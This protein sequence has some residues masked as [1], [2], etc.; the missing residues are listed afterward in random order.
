MSDSKNLSLDEYIES[1]E[2]DDFVKQ[3]K[4]KISEILKGLNT[5]KNKL[6]NKKD[7][8]SIPI[9]RTDD[10][11]KLFAELE[12][13][14][15]VFEVSLN[16]LRN[17]SDS[18]KSQSLRL[19][20]ENLKILKGLD[21]WRDYMNFL[22]DII[23]NVNMVQAFISRDIQKEEFLAYKE[24]TDRTVAA[25]KEREL[26]LIKSI[27]EVKVVFEQT[28]NLKIHDYYELAAKENQSKS[29]I[30]RTFFIFLII[31]SLTIIWFSM[32]TKGYFGLSGYDYYFFKGSLV[33]TSVT[34]ITYFLKQ[35]V[36][37]QK[38]ADQCKQT[39]LE[40]E[41]FPSYVAN[42]SNEDPLVADFRKELAMKYFGRDVDNKSN[43]ET[44]NILQDQMKNTTEMVKATVEVLKKSGSN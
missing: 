22:R 27:E 25:L 41:A 3:S 33:L 1:I 17:L 43:D 6:I 9:D 40:L 2:A 37:Y 21:N 39:K 18:I 13:V 11:V 29:D 5:L 4:N 35:S 38:M 44:S 30:N 12:N 8:F 15:F 34:L 16:N 19:V 10:F 31:L 20:I 28:K 36:K 32:V 7:E 24:D 42:L 26:E 14:F 23:H